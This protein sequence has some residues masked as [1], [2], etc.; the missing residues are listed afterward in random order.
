MLELMNDLPY[1]LDGLNAE[2]TVSRE[3]YALVFEPIIDE[4]REQ[5]RRMR[6]LY[7][8][9]PVF[10]GF[11]AGAAWEDLRIGL[12]SMKFF[13]GCAIVSDNT[14]IREASRLAGF[15]LPR[16]V[17]VFHNDSRDRAI[18]WLHSLP[19]GVAVSHRLLPEDGVVVVE[20]KQALHA[21]DFDP[22]V[23]TVDTW[24]EAEGELRG[25]VMQAHDFRGWENVGNFFRH[26]R[27]V[28]HRH[29]QLGRVALAAD[30]S[31]RTL[32]AALGEHF[33]NAEVRNLRFDEIDAAVA[34]AAA[35]RS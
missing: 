18:D 30:G 16:P 19:T 2:G 29:Q 34:W 9:G 8:L 5:G 6:V 25:L 32:A 21:Y 28:K 7:Q 14:W 20:I 31:V 1:G 33:V 12:N 26:L 13:D 22:V 17:R 24:L 23:L 15:F 10:E 27:F 3:D 35:G 11:R 4:A